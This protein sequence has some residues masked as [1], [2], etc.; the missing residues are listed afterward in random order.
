MQNQF[1][2]AAAGLKSWADR[3]KFIEK[4]LQAYADAGDLDPEK[5]VLHQFLTDEFMLTFTEEHQIEITVRITAT[6][7]A[8]KGYNLQTTDFY[9][10]HG[11]IVSSSDDVNLLSI[12]DPHISDLDING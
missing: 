12:Q 2:F 11:S 4:E 6:V 8:S 3:F 7:E 1:D 9:F 5:V 10:E